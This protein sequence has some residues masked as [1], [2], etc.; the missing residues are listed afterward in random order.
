MKTILCAILLNLCFGISCTAAAPLVDDWHWWTEEPTESYNLQYDEKKHEEYKNILLQIKP[1]LETYIQYLT[2]TQGEKSIEIDAQKITNKGR[3]LTADTYTVEVKT[4][5]DSRLIQSSRHLTQI[6]A[7]FRESN[8]PMFHISYYYLTPEY[9][10]KRLKIYP[11]L[12]IAPWYY[13]YVK[14]NHKA[15]KGNYYIRFDKENDYG[16]GLEYSEIELPEEYIIGPSFK[17]RIH[18]SSKSFTIN[19]TY[20]RKKIAPNWYY[21]EEWRGYPDKTF[22]H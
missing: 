15:P 11:Y 12:W 8:L 1:Q 7:I 14:K 5:R 6:Y 17:Y 22:Y 20:I 2:K 9:V 19:W 18:T 13:D 4:D 21:F 10:D 16:Y 3:W